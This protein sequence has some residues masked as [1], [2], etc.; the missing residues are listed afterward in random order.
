[1]LLLLLAGLAVGLF[2]PVSSS[3]RTLNVHAGQSIQRA[4]P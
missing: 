1:M 2:F 3:A 4:V